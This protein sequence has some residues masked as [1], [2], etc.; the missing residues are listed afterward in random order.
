MLASVTPGMSMSNAEPRSKR[1]V[2]P[3]GN[4][5]TSAP[6]NAGRSTVASNVKPP[7][8]DGLRQTAAA[9]GHGREVAANRG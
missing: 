9:P 7:V 3:A 8:A 5:S 2:G 4:D 6:M 1:E